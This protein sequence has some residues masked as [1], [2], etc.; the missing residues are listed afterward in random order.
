MSQGHGEPIPLPSPTVVV[1]R[2]LKEMDRVLGQPPPIPY[3]WRANCFPA[4][5]EGALYL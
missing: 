2:L 4:A 3:L 5:P 1:S